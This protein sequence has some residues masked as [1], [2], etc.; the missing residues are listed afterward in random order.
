[1]GMAGILGRIKEQFHDEE[2]ELFL[3]QNEDD[4]D[5]SDSDYEL[6]GDSE[7]EQYAEDEAEDVYI[8][9]E[10]EAASDESSSLD[11]IENDLVEYDPMDDDAQS[12]YD[13]DELDDEELSAFASAEELSTSE[14]E[15][16][17]KDEDDIVNSVHFA[18]E[19]HEALQSVRDLA[20]V[21]QQRLMLSV[22]DE[23]AT[24]SMVEAAMESLK[25]AV[26]DYESGDDIE[27]E[28]EEE[29]DLEMQS[30]LQS[31]RE[32]GAVDG[33]ALALRVSELYHEENGQEI[34]VQELADVFS[35]V[36]DLF[37]EE[38]AATDDGDGDVDPQD[39]AD[40]YAE[41]MDH[42]VEIA[43][44]HR[45][46]VV[47]K[48]TQIYDEENCNPPTKGAIAEMMECV[49]DCFAD[50]A[51][52]ELLDDDLPT[53]SEDDDS[54]YSPESDIADHS[55]YQFDALDLALY[56]SSENDHESDA[57]FDADRDAED[58]KDLYAEDADLDL[59]HSE[60]DGHGQ[61]DDDEE[62]QK[63]K[64]DELKQS[65]VESLSA[66]DSEYS[67]DKDG[68]RYFEDYQ[69]EY[70]HS[71]TEGTG[72]DRSDS[73]FDSDQEQTD[74]GDLDYNPD[75][76][77]FHYSVHSLRGSDAEREWP[78]GS[79]QSLM[80]D[81]EDD[82]AEYDDDNASDDDGDSRSEQEEQDE[83]E[84]DDDDDNEED[85]Q[86]LGED[87]GEQQEAE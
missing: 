45:E 23:L 51:I 83:S 71:D 57:D 12:L 49:V 19:W 63:E 10:H 31:V 16:E 78:S 27:E 17:T 47:A 33:E 39:F 44:C 26:I 43:K 25:E 65:E 2:R 40:L 54:S 76:D 67:P 62:E 29:L 20:K 8:E 42:V 69:A 1:M 56:R 5:D 68:A 77:L 36:Q 18:V 35:E 87:A 11:V 32:L 9:G 75:Y 79:E 52:H 24:D 30:A 60:D 81:A 86:H 58:S 22:D 84:D 64:E 7:A 41:A 74:S 37:A 85:E 66:E 6:D 72:T 14:F 50:E 4:D 55:E 61:D 48:L 34:T 21:D 38:A 53:D 13:H 80:T 28:E 59:A 3:E 46:E 73:H 70:A 15:D 82:S